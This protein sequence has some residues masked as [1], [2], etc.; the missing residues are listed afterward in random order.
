MLIDVA[1]KTAQSED[2]YCA[3]GDQVSNDEKS[4]NPDNFHIETRFVGL[5]RYD[6]STSRTVCTSS[7]Y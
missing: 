1:G 7:T 2:L 5:E 3:V 4:M 6:T